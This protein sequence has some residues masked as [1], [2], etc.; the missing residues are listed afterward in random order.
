MCY[1]LGYQGSVAVR[2]IVD[3]HGSI[4]NISV[5]KDEVGCGAAAEAIRV[6]K[7]M[8]KWNPAL[9]RGNP[10]KSYFVQTF[11]FKIY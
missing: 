10:V 6:M 4:S 3:E 5:V 7:T 9:K 1:E 2:F 8:P 11:R